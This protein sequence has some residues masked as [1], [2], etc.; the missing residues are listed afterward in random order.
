M[1]PRP[2]RFDLRNT[3]GFFEESFRI[4]TQSAR[5][6][7]EKTDEKESKAAIVIP[8]T[9]LA[10]ATKRNTLKRRYQEALLPFLLSQRGIHI[11]GIVKKNGGNLPVDPYEDIRQ[12]D[13]HLHS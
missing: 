13:H 8:K 12:L 9:V 5:W 3:T 2:Y 10:L 11:V 7:V 4:Q 1:L 6:F